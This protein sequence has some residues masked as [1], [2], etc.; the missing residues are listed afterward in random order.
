M[1]QDLDQNSVPIQPESPKKFPTWA[2]VLISVL[3]TGVI[4]ASGT[5]Y[6]LTHD[7][8]A[9]NNE[10]SVTNQPTNPISTTS[11]N[12][13]QV[14]EGFVYK[15]SLTGL[16]QDPVDIIV[17]NFDGSSKSKIQTVLDSFYLHA[18]G[19][20]NNDIS[21]NGRIVYSTRFDTEYPAPN[22]I[23]ISDN[24]SQPK[25]ILTL[26]KGDSSI[27]IG[28]I[29][30][31]KISPDGEKIAYSLYFGGSRSAQLWT[32][33]ADGT[34]NKMVID[35]T[36]IYIVEEGPFRLVPLAWS[37]DKT[38]VYMVTTTD[39]EATPTGM[40]IAD[41]ATAKI[42]K[43]K[44]PNVTLW[45]AS[46]SPDRKKVVYT[47][48]E[49]KYVPDSSI[50]EPGPPYSISVTDLETGAT[51]KILES[52]VDGYYAPVWS[53]DGKKIMYTTS[54]KEDYIGGGISIS[55]V[56]V[57]TKKSNVIV[58][59]T[60]DNSRVK[61]WAW[62]SNDRVIYTEESYTTGEVE[63]KV[64]TY[65]FTIKVDGTDKQIV[66]LAKDIVVFGSLR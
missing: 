52:Q 65:L 23:W 7:K 20:Y 35:D 32:M 45:H 49:W 50:P 18:T 16:I 46:L 41:L 61:S 26:P 58:T 4:V 44:T 29:E 37:K 55:V 24:G 22:S 2:I 25:N 38:K 5:Y 8:T 10:L 48:F 31:P 57:N 14:S 60:R 66:D 12:G 1:K 51:E 39:S 33:N 6:F 43:A 30:C 19:C 59:R 17:S 3:A 53:P 27:T 40:Y 36:G 15:K 9:V 21:Q 34:D 64:E 54:K 11:Q 63:N 47:T 13:H 56:D 42:Q 62:L 28:T